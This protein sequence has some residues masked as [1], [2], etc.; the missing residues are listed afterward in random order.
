MVLD[1]WTRDPQVECSISQTMLS[2]GRKIKPGKERG[3]RARGGA[4][5]K[6]VVRESSLGKVIFEK[7]LKEAREPN[8][9]LNI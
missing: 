1:R 6:R 4:I 7:D 5:L 3:P 9:G 8:V 2:V